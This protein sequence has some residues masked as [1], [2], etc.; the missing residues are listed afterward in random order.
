MLHFV[1]AGPIP[2][3]PSLLL[4]GENFDKLLKELEQT[5]DTIILDSPPVG[6]VTD[7]ILVMKKADLQL[8]VVRSGYTQRNYLKTIDQLRRTNKFDK[9][10]VIFNSLS[11]S[12]SYGY[13]YGYGYGHGY[14]E[15]EKKSRTFAATIKSLF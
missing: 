14:Y 4:L 13:G 9:L 7:G 11:G 3:N 15:D 5:Y 1:T 8:Y 10:T 12:G 6:L 2:T